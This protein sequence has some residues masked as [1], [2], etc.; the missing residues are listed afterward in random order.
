MKKNK[1][2]LF[3]TLL[4]YFFTLR[5][6]GCISPLRDTNPQAPVDKKAMENL[7]SCDDLNGSTDLETT[8]EYHFVTTPNTSLH[9]K[10]GEML[11]LPDIIS[12]HF[13]NTSNTPL[14]PKQEGGALPDIVGCHTTNNSGDHSQVVKPVKIPPIETD[15]EMVWQ[16]ITC[17]VNSYVRSKEENLKVKKELDELQN[18]VSDLLCRLEEI[19]CEVAQKSTMIQG[20]GKQVAD[21]DINAKEYL[22]AVDA[23]LSFVQDEIQLMVNHKK[24]LETFQMWYNKVSA[25]IGKIR[26]ITVNKVVEIAEQAVQAHEFAIKNISGLS[27]VKQEIEEKEVTAL[28]VLTTFMESSLGLLETAKEQKKRIEPLE[29]S[30]EDIRI[31]IAEATEKI[32]EEIKKVKEVEKYIASELVHAKKKIFLVQPSGTLLKNK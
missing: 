29:K 19:E 17:T 22:G 11:P 12:D 1:N 18:Q 28:E 32:S 4:F 14:N 23:L 5:S 16:V 25:M 2:N 9:S 20:V 8:T 6:A 10:S 13:S 15:P 21:N 3:I 24:E 7:S 31:K 30:I 27:N 26:A